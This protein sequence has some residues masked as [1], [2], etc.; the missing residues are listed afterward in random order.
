MH[1]TLSGGAIG[2]HRSSGVTD[3]LRKDYRRSSNS[4][5]NR[6]TASIALTALFTMGN[7][8]E[9]AVKQPAEEKVEKK[10]KESI[11]VVLSS[12]V[13]PPRSHQ[14]FQQILQLAHFVVDGEG[15]VGNVEDLHGQE[16][17]IV[18]SGELSDDSA[19]FHL[20]L[21]DPNLKFVH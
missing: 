18:M 5:R 21:S 19:V 15:S 17:L 1:R 7:S 10:E 4:S 6:W 9:T 8:G 13:S 20:A 11:S 12:S 2:E 14:T 3:K 16:A